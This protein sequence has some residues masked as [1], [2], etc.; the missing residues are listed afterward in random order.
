MQH[1]LVACQQHLPF[2]LPKYNNSWPYALLSADSYSS[3]I[4]LIVDDL[5]KIS[6]D[7]KLPFTN[8]PGVYLHVICH[9]NKTKDIHVGS[10]ASYQTSRA[11]NGIARRLVTRMKPSEAHRNTSLHYPKGS[12]IEDEDFWV[13][14]ATLLAV[15]AA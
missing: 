9:K 3:Q 6:Q 4:L 7:P 8:A 1:K 14:C 15:V 12:R 10:A 11:Q 13:I 2:P 5:S